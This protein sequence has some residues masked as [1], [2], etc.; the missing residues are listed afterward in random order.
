MVKHLIGAGVD[1]NAR[2]WDGWTALHTASRKGHDGI[3][4]ELLAAKCD[5][6][7][8]DSSGNCWSSRGWTAFHMASSNGHD[9]VVR[10]LLAAKCDA[11][12]VAHYGGP[13]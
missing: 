5:V 3:V 11:N 4:R 8:L 10:E 7:A 1:V 9:G 2:D 13:C 6:N 12:A